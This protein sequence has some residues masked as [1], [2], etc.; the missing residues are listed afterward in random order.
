M[1][2]ALSELDNMVQGYFAQALKQANEAKSCERQIFEKSF[3]GITGGTFWDQIEKDI[4]ASE[5]L[6]RRTNAR[7]RSIYRDVSI[8]E[9]TVLFMARLGFLM[10]VGDLYIGSDKLGHFFDTGY[11]YYKKDSLEEALT[12]GEMTERTYYGLWSTS[13]YSYGDL[14]ANFDGYR[15]WTQ[16]TQ[17]KNAYVTCNNNKWSQQ[18]RFTWSDHVNAAWDEGLNCNRYK[19]HHVTASV[20]ARITELGLTCPVQSSHCPGMIERYGDLAPRIVSPLCFY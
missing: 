17:G 14:A 1:E 10:K 5:T 8:L 19:N 11:E 4:E 9:G 15:F 2:D 16:L 12:Y 13:V 3:Q 6:D 20:N 18:R 7:K